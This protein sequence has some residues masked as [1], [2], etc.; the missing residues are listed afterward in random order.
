MPGYQSERL[1]DTGHWKLATISDSLLHTACVNHRPWRARWT[2]VFALASDGGA[3]GRKKLP[4]A[5]YSV[6]KE[7]VVEAA[8]LAAGGARLRE[9]F[10]PNWWLASLLRRPLGRAPC[11]S[12][13]LVIVTP[14]TPE[15]KLM[16][17]IFLEQ[18]TFALR[19]AP[20]FA[21]FMSEGWWRIPGSNR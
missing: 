2:S 20:P 1:L 17:Q 3:C 7:S 11:H 14:A 15:C 16:Q 10:S 13:E 6:V 4:F 21:A 19:W 12:P 8:G 9:S 5:G 18:P